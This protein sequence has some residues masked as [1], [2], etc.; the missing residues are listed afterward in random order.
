MKNLFQQLVPEY[1]RQMLHRVHL[2]SAINQ[3]Q[4]IGR[5]MLAKELAY[6][7]RTLRSDIEVLRQL[8]LVEIAK[9]GISLSSKGIEVLKA[10]EKQSPL[11]SN[12]DE[13]E[14]E[15][16]SLLGARIVKIARSSVEEKGFALGEQLELVLNDLLPHG[17]DM[18]AVTG[19]TTLA[20]LVSGLSSRL[21]VDREIEFVPAR[22]GIGKT[23]HIQAN[24]IAEAMA[25][26]INA[27]YQSLFVPEQV[28]TETYHAL[29]EE[30]S[31][32]LVLNKLEHVDVVVF[33]V[34]DAKTMAQRRMMSQA[35]MEELDQHDAVGE[36]FGV[37]FNPDGKV[38]LKLP[39]IGLHLSDVER[40]RFPIAVV[41][42]KQKVRALKAFMKMVPHHHVVLIIDEEISHSILKG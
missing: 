1:Y 20:S 4:P 5:R 9:Q 32:H 15:I 41:S 34:G 39:R 31:V 30:P 14:E 2:L 40:I 11:F 17:K 24:T 3:R 33:S 37:F 13:E 18:I 22:G 12:M 10:C 7:E 26:K 36:A 6:S 29:I 21:N 16:A 28:S 42:G 23:H 27:D 35:L 8:G 19:G 25:T 38:V